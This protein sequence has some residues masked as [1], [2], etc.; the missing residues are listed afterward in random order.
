MKKNGIVQNFIYNLSYQILIVIV[1]LITTPYVSRVLKPDGVGIYSYTYT[2]AAVFALFVSLGI[3]SYGQREI[4]YKQDLIEERSRIFWELCSIR[5][6]TVT[7]VSV[8]Y[9]L[10]AAF[11]KEYKVFL[12]LQYFLIIAEMFDISWYF[13][14]MEDFKVV[15]KRNIVIKLLATV[16]IFVFVRTE[17][18]VWK[19]VLFNSLSV[20]ISNLI[21]MTYVKNSIIRVNFKKLNFQRH[22]RG[23]IELFIPL[24]AVQIYSNLDKI[25]LGAIIQ[26]N[27]ENGYFEQA[28]KIA[29]LLVTVVVSLNSVMFSRIAYLYATKKNKEEFIFLYKRIL[30][31]IWM[32][33]LPMCFGLFAIS[34]NFVIWF[35][36][37]EYSSVSILL[38]ISCPLIIFSAVGNFVGQQYLNPTG[39]QNK[40]TVAYITAAVVNIAL[41]VLLIPIFSSVGALLASN[42][43]EF[44]SCGIQ[45]RYLKKSDYNFK[46]SENLYKYVISAMIMLI[47]IY[48]INSILSFSPFMTSMLDIILGAFIYFAML[49]VLRDEIIGFGISKISK[50]AWLK[51]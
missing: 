18:D 11:Y 50:K 39:Q 10:I 13:R 22:I 8:I 44:I 23:I 28:R 20:L 14:G 38:K 3:S 7:V 15:V 19:Y 40:A 35:F 16:C 2:I 21:L 5:I 24:I 12:L 37:E 25:M 9:L 27:V 32:I 45:I 49:F 51:N 4:A 26:N 42:V 36:G 34:D 46:L 43:A 17:G 41:N 30:K 48:L 33:L 1:P 6:L 47:S 29:N 31:I